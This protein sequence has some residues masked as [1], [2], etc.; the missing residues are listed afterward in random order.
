MPQLIHG[1]P[2]CFSLALLRDIKFYHYIRNKGDS[3]ECSGPKVNIS[4]IVQDIFCPAVDNVTKVT[5][6]IDGKAPKGL[7]SL[8]LSAECPSGK[9]GMNCSKNCSVHCAGLYNACSHI[10]GSCAEGCDPGYTGETCEKRL[11]ELF[12]SPIAIS[13]CVEHGYITQLFS[14]KI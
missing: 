5:V 3:V 9:H 10:N 4:D 12:F 8:Y 14:S 1:C 2:F 13:T 11:K 7:C 6:T